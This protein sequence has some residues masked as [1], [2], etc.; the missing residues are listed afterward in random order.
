MMKMLNSNVFSVEEKTFYFGQ[1]IPSKYPNGITEKFKIT[2]VHKI[3]CEVNFSVEKRQ[4]SGDEDELMF[5]VEPKNVKINPHEVKY[6]KVTFNPDIMTQ[7]AAI[8]TAKVVNGDQNPKTH[9]LQFDLRGEGVMPT[10]RV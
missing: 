10:L 7:Y 3:P 1:I 8:F 9:C 6:V 5:D 4:I 2:N